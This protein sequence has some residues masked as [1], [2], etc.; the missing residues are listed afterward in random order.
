MTKISIIIPVY[1]VEKYLARCLDSVILQTCE[2]WEAVC[3]N[4]GST[5][6]S[7][8][9]LT[10][11]AK[12]DKRIKIINQI[13]KGVSAARNSGLDNAIGEYITFMDSDDVIHPQYLAL[14]LENA[15]QKT[16]SMCSFVNFNDDKELNFNNPIICNNKVSNSLDFYAVSAD[17]KM[18]SCGK[19]F[20]KDI[21]GNYRFNENCFY[22]ENAL[23]NADV[24]NKNIQI[25]E[26]NAPLYYYFKNPNSLVHKKSSIKKIMS[27]LLVAE[28]VG[29]KFKGHK[30]VYKTRVLK[31]LSNALKYIK[32]CDENLNPAFEKIKELYK[33]KIISYKGLSLKRKLQLF[34]IVN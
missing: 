31:S 15:D 2:D 21:I 27:V 3:V 19:L 11:Y 33:N 9:I 10:D 4:D 14:L 34:L 22:S 32:D 26:T 25:K 8:Q 28:I 13:N 7:L 29:N 24:F 23:F 5:D 1:N 30:G 16:I 12:K 20:Y 18:P 17:M 6:N